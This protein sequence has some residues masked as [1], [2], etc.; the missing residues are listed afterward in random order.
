MFLTLFIGSY[1]DVEKLHSA[2]ENWR[3][4]KSLS[5]QSKRKNSRVSIQSE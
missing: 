4:T 5:A 3:V 2:E 1:L